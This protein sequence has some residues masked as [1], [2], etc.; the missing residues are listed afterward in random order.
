MIALMGI[1][2]RCIF[3]IF[4]YIMFRY[5]LGYEI[6]EHSKI[7]IVILIFIAALYLLIPAIFPDWFDLITLIPI[8]IYGLLFC[9]FRELKIGP[10]LTYSAFRVSLSNFLGGIII[11]VWRLDEN[12]AEGWNQSTLVCNILI[13]IVFCIIAVILRKKRVVIH[14]MLLHIPLWVYLIFTAVLAIPTTSYF[15]TSEKDVLK[16]EGIMTMIDGL[17]GIAM[18]VIMVLGVYMYFQRSELRMQTDLK[19]RCI[20]E[21]TDQYHL[22]YEKQQELRHFRHDSSAHLNIIASLA[23]EAGDNRVADYV[24]E[25]IA[26]EED[27]RHLATGNIIGDAI[28]NQYYCKGIKDGVEVLLMGQ[29]AEN[30]KTSETD[31]CVILSNVISNAYEAAE[32]C[33]KNR[34]III[35]FSSFRDTQFIRIQNPAI[36]IPVIKSGLIKADYTTKEDKVNHGLGIRNI[37]DA[38]ERIGG[39]IQ[40]QTEKFGEQ[41]LIITEIEIPLEEDNIKNQ[42]LHQK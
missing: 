21:Q 17:S 33:E 1:L 24:S 30:F 22:L 12:T 8:L 16:V 18:S 31:L 41:D 14:Q 36:D 35:T 11:A 23:K 26:R 27:T 2:I 7:V 40:W 15:S 29:F 19:E 13:L 20:K 5:I 28:V 34:K 42:H 4:T 32:K 37:M 6:R 10:I 38:A 3:L 9:V 25:L 39:H